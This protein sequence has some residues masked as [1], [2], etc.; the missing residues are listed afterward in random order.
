MTYAGAARPPRA[1]AS[2][3]DPLRLWAGRIGAMEGSLVVLFARGWR[4]GTVKLAATVALAFEVVLHWGR[5][6]RRLAR[7]GRG[8]GQ[9][10]RIRSTGVT[11][12]P[13]FS[14]RENKTESNGTFA[15][16]L[17]VGQRG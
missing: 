6:A 11:E 9:Q 5:A 3:F 4:N 1:P 15:L 12:C 10:S 17:P 13:P 7:S 8:E 14:R 16:G 2:G